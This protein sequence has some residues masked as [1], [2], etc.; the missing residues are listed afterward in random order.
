MELFFRNEK[1]MK[2]DEV[3][4]LLSQ[5]RIPTALVFTPTNLESEKSKFLNSDS[6]NPIF[7]YRVVKNNN[8]EILKKLSSVKEIS[9]VDP[10]ISDFY[11]QL[12][13]SKKEANDLMYAVGDNE[14]VTDISV[15]RYGKPSSKLFR[16][17]ARVLRGKMDGYHVVD[18]NIDRGEILY[19]DDIVK[20][21]NIAFKELGLDGW[22]VNKSMNIAKNGVKLGIKKNEIL[23][24]PGIERTKFKLRKTLVHEVGTHA[25]RSYYGLRSGFEALSNANIPEYL[26]VEEGLAT[27]N[28]NNMGLLSADWLKNKAALAWAIYI[29]EELSFRELYNALLGVLPKYAAFDVVFRVKRGLGDTHDSGMY[30]KDVVYFRGFRRVRKKLEEDPSLYNKLYA[31]KI[32]FKQCEWVEDGLIPMPTNIP[33]KAKWLEIFKKAGI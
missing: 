7:E 13:D 23:V 31:G 5:L 30:Y 20:V 16:N 25:L 8:R 19:Y 33:D 6:Y 1:T 14:S 21:F 24:D 3:T 10:R 28:E 11:I 12:I 4:G 18:K 26:D 15:H 9:D 2:L 27:W 29:G 17:A 22:S 32:T